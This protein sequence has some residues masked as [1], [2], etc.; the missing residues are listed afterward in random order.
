[1]REI[2]HFYWPASF[3]ECGEVI[4]K[5]KLLHFF[6][7]SDSVEKC[8]KWNENATQQVDLALNVFFMVYFFIRVRTQ[9]ASVFSNA[10]LHFLV[11]LLQTR[12]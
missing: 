5:L 12:I 6:P 8:Q 7:N 4:S 11:N 10:F 3:S 2:G 1:M 9:F